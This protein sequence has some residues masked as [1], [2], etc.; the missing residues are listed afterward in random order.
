MEVTR[1]IYCCP[2]HIGRERPLDEQYSGLSNREGGDGDGSEPDISR[3]GWTNASIIRASV[4]HCLSEVV[5]AL[6]QGN[7]IHWDNTG[8]EVDELCAKAF[9][10]AGMF[11][12]LC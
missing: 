3:T 11:V 12:A 4:R 2:D 8:I 6:A 10:A 9:S 7:A 1:P 5:A